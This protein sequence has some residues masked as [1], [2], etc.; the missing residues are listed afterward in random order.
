MIKALMGIVNARENIQYVMQSMAD[1]ES[2]P[3]SGLRWKSDI[4][5]RR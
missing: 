3:I 5:T 4:L 2:E 1:I